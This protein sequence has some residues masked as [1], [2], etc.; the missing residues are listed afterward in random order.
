[1]IRPRG[2]DFYYSEDEFDVMRRDALMAKQ[3]GADGV[4]FGLLDA[5]ANVDVQRTRQLVHLARPL[6]TTFHR[7]FDVSAD[8]SRSLEDVVEAEADRILTS[9]AAQTA[10]EGIAM[11]R[12]LVEDAK[13]RVIVMACGG[14]D[15]RNAGR[16]V[17]QTGVREI[18]AGLRTPI[19][20]QYGSASI[21]TQ[22][23]IVSESRV[24]QLV[25]AIRSL[26]E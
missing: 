20:K 8:L 16:V 6:K 19:A 9:G 22:P 17:Q 14:I 5:D 2:G 24:A 21:L 13:D 11:I 3:L 18:H 4:V 26:K 7:A 15:E 12:R 10:V 25:H 23:F 1:M